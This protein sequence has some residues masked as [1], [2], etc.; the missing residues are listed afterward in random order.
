MADIEKSVKIALAKAGWKQYQLAEAIRPATT[1]QQVNR[2][3]SSGNGVRVENLE[4]MA[5]ALG[6]KVS[7][8]VALGE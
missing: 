2:W 3:I 8:L 1:P 5:K 4:K 6:M 7:E